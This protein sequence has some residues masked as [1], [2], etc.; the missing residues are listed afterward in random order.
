MVTISESTLEF[1][2]N[3]R[4]RLDIHASYTDHYDCIFD[5]N[6]IGNPIYKDGTFHQ[7]DSTFEYDDDYEDHF[8]DA[9]SE[10]CTLQS[11]VL[12]GDNLKVTITEFEEDKELIFVKQ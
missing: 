7:L 5:W 3:G 12:D 9:G 4:A 11:V 6:K 8:V 10:D 2:N 1:R